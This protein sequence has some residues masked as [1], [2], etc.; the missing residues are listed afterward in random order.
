MQ[1]HLS[2][3]KT[4]IGRETASVWQ[5]NGDPSEKAKEM[6]NNAAA[7][8]AN[9]DGGSKNKHIFTILLT[10]LDLLRAMIQLL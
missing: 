2:P 5:H 6:K 7:N 10:S 9:A 4:M 3:K 8:A 1:D